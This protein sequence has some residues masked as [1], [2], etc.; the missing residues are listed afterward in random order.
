MQHAAQLI[1]LPFS[2]RRHAAEYDLFPVVIADLGKHHLER[3]N[4]ISANR[5]HVTTVYEERDG[6]GFNRRRSGLARCSLLF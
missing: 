2:L 5:A 3:A 4:L 1:P 6:S